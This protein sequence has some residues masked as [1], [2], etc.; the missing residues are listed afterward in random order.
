MKFL[1]IIF[2]ILVCSALSFDLSSLFS[3]PEPPVSVSEVDLT[4]YSGTWYEIARL[5]LFFERH[6]YCST[7]TYTADSDGSFGIENSCRWKAPNGELQLSNSRAVPTDSAL[8]STKTTGNFEIKYKSIPAFSFTYKVI[9]LDKDYQYAM[10]GT[11][12]KTNLWILSKTNTMSDDVYYKLVDHALAEG[13]DVSKI[14]KTYHGPECS[15]N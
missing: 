13:Y 4:K 8:D 12:K 14:L 9:A 1:T 15:E 6:C 10:V 7:A 2:A 5:P 11:D 3:R